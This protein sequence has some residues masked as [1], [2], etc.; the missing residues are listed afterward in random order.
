M[1]DISRRKFLQ[2]AGT[3][4]AGVAGLQAGSA[5]PSEAATPV[6]QAAPG[7]A[8]REGV[9]LRHSDRAAIWLYL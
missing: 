7:K 1:R 4:V 2:D 6:G 9:A 8:Q 3:V 5:T